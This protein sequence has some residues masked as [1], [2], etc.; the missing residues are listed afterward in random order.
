MRR[1]L[2]GWTSRQGWSVTRGEEDT[3][4]QVCDCT[5]RPADARRDEQSQRRRESRLIL[6]ETMKM[7]G[8]SVFDFQF[9]GII[10]EVFEFRISFS[11]RFIWGF[12]FWGSNFAFGELFFACPNFEFHFHALFKN[13]RL[14]FLWTLPCGRP[15]F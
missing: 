2:D 9:S 4:G 13:K 10:S 11:D 1:R 12:E 8:C 6:P 14:S 3:N 5:S 7:F 15:R